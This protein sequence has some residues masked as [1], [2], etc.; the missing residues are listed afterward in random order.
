M[1]SFVQK[2]DQFVPVIIL[3]RINDLVFWGAKENSN[4][5]WRIPNSA[6]VFSRS[7]H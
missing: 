6:Q 7:L 5:L 3:P 4:N 2:D 1:F